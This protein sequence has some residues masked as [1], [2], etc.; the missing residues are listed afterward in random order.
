MALVPTR[1]RGWAKRSTRQTA[2]A[3]D[4]RLRLRRVA[5]LV[6]PALLALA[7]TACGKSEDG[8]KMLMSLPPPHVALG[9]ARQFDAPV[10]FEYPAQ[11]TGSREVDIRARVAGHIERRHFAEGGRVKAGDLL[12][13]LDTRPFEAA[14]SR[15]EAGLAQARAQ[16][17]QAQAQADQAARESNRLAP[18]AADRVIGQKAADDARSAADTANAGLEAAKAL[19]LQADAVL[20]Q[21]RL[22]LGY[23][24][25]T[26][27]ISG[28]IGRA[29]KVE[30]ALVGPQDPERLTGLM[31][32]D[33][34]YIVWS[35][36][37]SERVRFDRDLRDGR[38]RLPAGGL[39]ARVRLA[40]GTEVATPGRISFTSPGANPKTGAFE[41]RASLP[42]GDLRVRPGEFVRIVLTGAT[43][44]GAVVVPQ[45]A[46]LDG[47]AQKM[48]L[49]VEKKGADTV[50]VPI[51]VEVGEW[52]DLPTEQGGRA[53]V[54]RK[55][56]Q[57][58]T[59]IITDGVMRLKPGM[60]VVVDA[61][62]TAAAAPAAGAAPSS[63]AAR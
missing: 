46:V 40:D 39:A 27:P 41:Y 23:A 28:L 53:W 63:A 37:D 61:A 14:V 38:I 17:L 35:L 21:A 8:P 36:A 57:A 60:P 47:P 6:A 51:P 26:A 44:P 7:L 11:A 55:G 2:A 62:P 50:V 43:L 42:N 49:T 56:L 31:Q 10:S 13:T 34:L 54:I 12:Y 22:D 45:R 5:G 20:R 52:V 58:G 24:R 48:V 3:R 33:P 30:G 59:R 16:V 18:L 9:E 19:V 32:V 29:E 15:A 4:R 1:R 25:V